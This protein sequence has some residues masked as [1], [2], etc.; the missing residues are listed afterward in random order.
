MDSG[1]LNWQTKTSFCPLGKSELLKS[2]DNQYLI[3]STALESMLRRRQ[4]KCPRRL[5]LSL[6]M[7][8]EGKVWKTKELPIL[9]PRSFSEY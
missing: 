4:G 5:N 7:I 1:R 9:G 2:P 8:L 6:K 3:V